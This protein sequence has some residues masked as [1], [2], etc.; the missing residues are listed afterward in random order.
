M[1]ESSGDPE[2][3][4]EAL[5]KSVAEARRLSA[6]FELSLC[7]AARAVVR[8]ASAAG[9]AAGRA[10]TADAVEARRHLDALG[11]ADTPVTSLRDRW[12]AGPLATRL[13]EG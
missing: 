13:A 11:V 6:D 3:A 10:V 1:S 4:L 12:P 9:G 8:A 7:L 5:D 2:A